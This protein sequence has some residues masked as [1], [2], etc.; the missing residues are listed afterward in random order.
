MHPPRGPLGSLSGLPQPSLDTL[1]VA[2]V[3]RADG[4]CVAC[5]MG[6]TALTLDAVLDAF[7]ALEARDTL[8]RTWVVARPVGK[9]TARFSVLHE[10]DDAA[11]LRPLTRAEL[12]KAYLVSRAGMAYCRGC[13]VAAIDAPPGVLRAACMRVRGSNGIRDGEGVCTSCGRRRLVLL[14]TTHLG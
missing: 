2:L 6:G 12:V 10:A 9:R 14:A 1:T 13:L 8:F 5:I 4:M 3:I 7:R 11:S